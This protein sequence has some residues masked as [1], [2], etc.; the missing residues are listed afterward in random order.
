MRLRVDPTACRDGHDH[1]HEPDDLKQ[2]ARQHDRRH[3]GERDHPGRC[4]AGGE[5]AMQRNRRRAQQQ[6]RRILVEEVVFE[7]EERRTDDAGNRHDRGQPRTQ[8]DPQHQLIHQ[9]ADERPITLGT[10]NTATMC[11]R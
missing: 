3:Q 11:G 1:A 4:A 10:A 2:A 7:I 6:K 9:D 8:T 5:K